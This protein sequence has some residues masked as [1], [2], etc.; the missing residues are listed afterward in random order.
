MDAVLGDLR[1]I[2]RGL[3]A[4][5]GFSLVVVTTV[6]FGIGA[7]TALFSLVN[8]ILL[9][10]LPYRDPGGLVAL[11]SSGPHAPRD[12]FSIPDYLDFAERARTLSGIGAWSRWGAN[13]TG[14]GEPELLQ[15]VYTAPGT[16]ALL[17]VEPVLGRLPLP[18][19]ERSGGER[20]VLLGHGVWKRRFAADPETLGRVLTLN[21]ERFTIVGVLPPDFVL[22]GRDVDVVVPLLLDT[23]GRSAAR[24]AAFLRPL[25][26]LGPGVSLHQADADLDR[27]AQ[28]LHR[29]YPDTNAAKTAVTVA[30]LHE[31]I[32]GRVR[33]L[34]LT[35]QGAVALV[36]AIGCANLANLLLSRTGAR[37]QEL[38]I[39]SALGASRPRLARLVV[40]ETLALSLAGGGLGL[41]LGGAGMNVLVAMGPADLPRRVQVTMSVQV[42]LFAVGLSV[43][44]GFL[45]GLLPALRATRAETQAS[46]KDGGRSATDEAG[47]T[48]RG[49][50]VSAEVALAL[51]AP[52]RGEPSHPELRSARAG[53]SGLRAR[54][55]P[56]RTAFAAA[57]T[58]RRPGRPRRL[59]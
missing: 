54:R 37:R 6:A 38:A 24:S 50:L 14:E 36:L 53:R 18:E 33:T 5:P 8:G 15:G 55:A 12:P 2:L 34:I 51:G 4:R 35:L 31:E 40:G 19:E 3:M 13:L 48:A 58:V 17:G 43:L 28:E 39:R 59:P 56:D 44:T 11:F 27:I 45:S 32:V 21:A 52:H 46:L 29:Q 16:L 47:S 1:S 30:P 25:A 10:P 42:A 41:L 7:N 20:V 23:D 26:R 22:P 49:F 57:G 9:S